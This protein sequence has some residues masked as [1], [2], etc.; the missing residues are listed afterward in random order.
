VQIK[1][2]TDGKA[3][4][5][6]DHP[7]LRD[8]RDE[9]RRVVDDGNDGNDEDDENVGEDIAEEVDRLRERVVENRERLDSGFENYEEVLDYL[10]ETTD[11][12][13]AR[14]DVLARALVS[15]R[16]QAR[17]F[18]TANAMRAV[19]AELARTAN[20]HGIKRAKCGDC[21]MSVIIALLTEPSCPHC[22]ATFEDIEPK[23]GFF[24]SNRLVV[25]RP[26]ALGGDTIDPDAD[27]DPEATDLLSEVTE[28]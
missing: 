4:A 13:D 5:D 21:E 17:A 10:T 12:L 23:Q 15:V 9:L 26:P 22:G 18:A 3:P 1:R 28:E 19:T 27:I 6:H 14:L 16:D 11:E 24:G 2:E 8:E 25:G 7:G 20:R